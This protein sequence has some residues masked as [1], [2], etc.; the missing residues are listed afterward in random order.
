MDTDIHVTYL[1]GFVK[2]EI[3]DYLIQHFTDS[4]SI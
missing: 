4:W 1:E 3:I 2:E